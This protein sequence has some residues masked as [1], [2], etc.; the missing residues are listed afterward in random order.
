MST[1]IV[2]IETRAG[3]LE[4]LYGNTEIHFIVV[5][6]DDQD[7]PT[8]TGPFNPTLEKQDLEK[9]AKELCVPSGLISAQ[10]NSPYF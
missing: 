8:V 5:D 2:I 4:A 1:P 3:Q 6:R 10:P 7:N 9:F